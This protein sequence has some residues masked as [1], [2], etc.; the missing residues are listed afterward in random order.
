MCVYIII[1]I[2]IIDESMLFRDHDDDDG[3]GANQGKTDCMEKGKSEKKEINYQSM[4]ATIESKKS[5]PIS[6]LHYNFTLFDSHFRQ[7]F[8]SRLIAVLVVNGKNTYTHILHS[9][10]DS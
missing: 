5:F 8:F 1:I 7:I 6:I 9:F 2:I 4:N 10:G 3:V